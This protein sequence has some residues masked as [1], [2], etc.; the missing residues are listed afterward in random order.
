MPTILIANVKGGVSKTATVAL[1]ACALAE[2]GHPV[3]AVDTDPQASLAFWAQLAEDAGTPLPY[4]VLAATAEDVA[5]VVAAQGT[6]FVLI[7][8]PPG[9]PRILVAGLQV[10][11][12]V[13]VPVRHSRSDVAEALTTLDLATAAGVPASILFAQVRAGTAT[14]RDA[15]AELRAVGELSVAE[16]VIPMREAINAAF[17]TRPGTAALVHHRILADEVLAAFTTVGAE[18]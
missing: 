2:M 3:V 18:G 17:G 11:E 8:S 16:T 4:P 9:D 7:D 12:L 10:A 6:A 1:L 5:S 13:L 15:M 14:A